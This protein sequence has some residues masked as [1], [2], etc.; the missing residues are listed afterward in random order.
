MNRRLCGR[1]F[2]TA[3]S[4]ILTP[5][6]ARRAYVQRV[7][8]LLTLLL[9]GRRRKLDIRILLGIKRVMI[10]EIKEGSLHIEELKRTHNTTPLPLGDRSRCEK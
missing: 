6:E 2:Q 5:H 3:S 9:P 7:I 1:T 4:G 8:R 10:I